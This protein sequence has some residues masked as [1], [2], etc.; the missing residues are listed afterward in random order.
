MVRRGPFP[1]RALVAGPCPTL[2][3]CPLRARA[4]PL[5]AGAVFGGATILE[6]LTPR[7]RQAHSSSRSEF[8]P[9]FFGRR[10]PSSPPASLT[11]TYINGPRRAA[12]PLVR[13]PVISGHFGPS[14]ATACTGNANRERPGRPCLKPMAGPGPPGHW[15]GRQPLPALQGASPAPRPTTLAHRPAPLARTPG[16][17]LASRALALPAAAELPLCQPRSSS[18]F[19]DADALRRRRHS[20]A[21]R[22]RP[23]TR[24]VGGGVARASSVRVFC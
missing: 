11:S 15:A 9:Y 5:C 16:S 20:A 10:C 23:A 6:F 14:V 19:A 2:R 13:Q 17:R 8:L 24:T 18:D 21:G 22:R 7:R 3:A 1:A 12:T 4:L